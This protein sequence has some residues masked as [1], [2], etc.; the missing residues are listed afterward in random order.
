M[1]ELFSSV[2]HSEYFSFNQ[3][4]YNGTDLY[5]VYRSNEKNRLLTY[6][7]VGFILG[8]IIILSNLPV[9]VSSGLILR[10]GKDT[11]VL[12]SKTGLFCL[13]CVHQI[14]EQLVRAYLM[15]GTYT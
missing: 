10:K 7:Y 6:R 4:D 13:F 15:V 14:G 2:N 12:N 5:E 8:T 1:D 3:S 9:V 11:W